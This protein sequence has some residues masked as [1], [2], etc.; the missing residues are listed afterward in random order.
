V[1]Y[2]L[3][4]DFQAGLDTRKADF[5]APAGS[6]RR[7][8]NAHITRGG[9]IE[10]RKA[11]V[12]VADATPGTF[13]L[14]IVRGQLYVFGSAP[15]PPALSDTLRYQRLEAP[16][17]SPMTAL[18][19][20]ANFNGR[21]YAIAEYADGNVLHFYDGNLVT[22]WTEISNDLSGLDAVA[23]SLAERIES[24]TGLLVVAD[25]ASLTITG[26]YVDQV[27]NI[28]PDSNMTATEIQAPDE[29]QPQITRIDLTGD[30]LPDIT[31]QITIG[32]RDFVVL[33]RAAG[34]GRTALTL[35]DRVYSTAQSLLRF[36]GFE[37]PGQ[38][39]DI[40]QPDATQWN[41]ADGIG[42]GFINLSTQDSG[43]ETLTALASYQGE[44]AVFSRQAIHIRALAF[45]VAQ[46]RQ[47]QLL[48]N[49]GTSSPRSVVSYGEADVFFLSQS[50]IRSLRARDSSN[51]AA[52]ADV[53]TPIDDE[54]TQYLATLPAEARSL[55]VAAVEPEYGRYC[56]AVG[57]RVYVYSQF[58]GSKISAWSSYELGGQVTDMAATPRRFY[59]RLNNK[60]YLYGGVSG[61]EY[62]DSQVDVVIPFIDA[63]KPGTTKQVL[64]VDVGCEGQWAMWVR[65]DPNLPEFEEYVGEI[66]G[67]T[68]GLQA[69]LP[70]IAQ[71]THF[72]LRLK[73][74]G[75]APAKLGQVIVHFDSGEES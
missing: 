6:L 25:G 53:G 42:A 62:D 68:Y 69:T 33:G 46:M 37:D 19:S 48:R 13:G 44:L 59:V 54:V 52:S 20:V 40:P 63:G 31:Y 60:V 45:D 27:Y 49:I 30:Y 17:G 9:E 74:R 8:T 51:S 16:N 10:K 2:Y 38:S 1:A 5:S 29:N 65:P 56:L 7:C 41:L 11:F 47:L 35:Q 36:S 64:S 61:T 70:A 4:A 43:S 12:E 22:Q 14:H 15:R 24:V 73:S 72:G 34:T 57:N 71:T 66:D 26:R 75:S 18:L 3:I 28:V 67:S 21:V 58:P 32:T 55:A 39:G 23:L 50:G